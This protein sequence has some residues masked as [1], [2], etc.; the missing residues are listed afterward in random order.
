MKRSKKKIRL[1]Q[2]ESPEYYFKDGFR[3]IKD[4]HYTYNSYV[5]I[6][7]KDRPIYDTFISEFIAFSQDYYRMAI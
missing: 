7:W 5:K 2:S 3:F 6:R 1:E 4:Y